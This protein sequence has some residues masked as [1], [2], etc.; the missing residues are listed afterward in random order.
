MFLRTHD[1]LYLSTIPGRIILV[2]RTTE[3]TLMLTMS[4]I[5]LS[6]H[7][8]KSSGYVYDL[9]ALLTEVNAW[10]Q[11]L[12]AGIQYGSEFRS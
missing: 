4:S 12:E 6:E 11:Y 10:H 3:L 7:R 8:W 5:S 2:S 1:I 9:P